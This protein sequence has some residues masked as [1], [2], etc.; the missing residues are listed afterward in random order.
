[1]NYL[2]VTINI[3]RLVLNT[4]HQKSYLH[5]QFKLV[6]LKFEY[7]SYPAKRLNNWEQKIV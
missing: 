1:M 4:L 5:D 3:F 7:L 6:H 2:Y